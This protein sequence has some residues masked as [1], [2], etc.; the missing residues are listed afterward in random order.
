MGDRGNAMKSAAFSSCGMTMLGLVGAFG[1]T[2]WRLPSLCAMTWTVAT[3]RADA[4]VDGGRGRGREARLATP[5]G[6]AEVAPSLL[7]LRE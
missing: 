4:D 2:D 7:G 1:L 5:A 6:G 3:E